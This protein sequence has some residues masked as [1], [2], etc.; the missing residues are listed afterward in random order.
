M[1][2]V[3][4][5]MLFYVYSAGGDVVLFPMQMLMLFYVSRTDGDVVFCFPYRW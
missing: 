3:Q 1:F 4:V 2:A 5:V